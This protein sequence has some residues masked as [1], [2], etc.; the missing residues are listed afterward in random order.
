MSIKFQLELLR[1]LRQR[2]SHSTGFTLIELMVV[3]AILGVLMAL[4]VPRF[5]NAKDA[6]DAGARIGDLVAK[7]KE[8][9]VFNASG[10]LGATPDGCTSAATSTYV[11]TWSKG[12]VNLKCLSETA[13]SA[14]MSIATIK[15]SPNG[16]MTCALE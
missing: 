3:V 5:L 13:Y 1:K 11:A 8:C 4:A 16:S 9:S 15:V 12:V 7:A 6:A 10:S 14:A 2:K